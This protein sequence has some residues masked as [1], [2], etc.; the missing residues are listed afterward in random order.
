MKAEYPGIT[1]EQTA[2][3]LARRFRNAVMASGAAAGA[4]AVAPGIGTAAGIAAM[5]P[6]L[7][8]YMRESAVYVLA[9]SQ[10]HGVRAL[11]ADER[12]RAVVLMVLVGGSVAAGTNKAIG[13]VV[14]NVAR[15]PMAIAWP[16][17][18]KADGRIR[19]Q[20][21]HVIDV[22]PT[23]LELVGIPEAKLV[24][25]IA[26]EPMDGTSF[27]YTFDA[28]DAPE[29]HI[30]QYFEM[31]GSRGIYKDGWWACTR[32]DKAPWDMSPQTMARF[33]PGSGWD[34]DADPWEL[35][36]LPEDFSQAR[37]IAT[38]HPDRLKELQDLWWAEAERN[39]ALPLLGAFCVF[40]GI[41]PPLPTNTRFAFHGDVQNV[42]R[43]M[44]PRILGRSYSIEADLHIPE[45]GAEGVIVANADHIGGFGL[46]VDE[47]S[48]LH[49]TYS[50]LG[51]ETYRQVAT[52]P[53]PTGD[54][55]V[56]M[57]F[58]ADQATP[59]TGGK[60]TLLANGKV[61][62]TGEIPRTVPVAFTSYGGMDIGRDN[63]LP[64]D[65][66]YHDKSP[67]AFTGTVRKVVF[68]LKPAPI[69]E[70]ADLHQIAVQAGMA[71]G[72]AG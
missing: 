34:P 25:G 66:A 24:D 12:R 60:V 40:Y 53:L 19:G 16:A 1:T 30:M 36:Y 35:Y 17:R 67:Y 58:E 55:S 59:G 51:V 9:M 46:W 27:A 71:H 5:A 42:Q 38:D 48:I 15:D 11:D 47:H 49:H 56:R 43:G 18:I 61:I 31:L 7:Y 41:V 45:G 13:Q 37:N 72:A 68:D 63:G 44:T 32:L 3:K 33:G 8:L 57:L 64:V 28:A 4:A 39:R 50:F 70:Q 14:P 6:D 22:G 54:V 52:E 69:D 29:Q 62:G 26:Q 23:I 21:T 20:F 2:R 65:L 10:I